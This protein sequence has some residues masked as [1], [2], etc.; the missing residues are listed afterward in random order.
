M[1]FTFDKSID[2]TP[3]IRQ[4]VLT[5]MWSHTCKPP[6]K[7]RGKCVLLKI[8]LLTRM[9]FPIWPCFKTFQISR[10]LFLRL[11]F[12]LIYFLIIHK[13]DSTCTTVDAVNRGDVEDPISNSI[14]MNILSWLLICHS[15]KS[16]IYKGHRAL[17]E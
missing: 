16:L 6:P 1:E 12:N 8:Q 13:Y 15:V 4:D 11:Y 17:A 5:Y 14:C 9:N 3:I 2:L 7:H 10:L